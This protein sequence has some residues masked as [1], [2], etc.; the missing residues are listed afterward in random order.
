M[1][2]LYAGEEKQYR[3]EVCKAC[4]HYLKVVDGQRIGPHLCLD[5]ENLATLHLDILAQREGY[6]RGAPY[7]LLI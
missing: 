6:R 1:K 2:Y 7:P 4:Q 3:L 5:V